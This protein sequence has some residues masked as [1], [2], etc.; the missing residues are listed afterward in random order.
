MAERKKRAT[1]ADLAHATDLSVKTVSIALRHGLGVSSETRQRVLEA[2]KKR[3]YG[4][5][6]PGARPSL[7]KLTIGACVP[8]L[9]EHY[10]ELA[11]EII[12]YAAMRNYAVVPQITNDNTADELRATQMFKRMGVF[13]VIL[14]SSRIGKA[15][16]K[17]LTDDGIAVVPIVSERDHDGI[18]PFPG[19]SPILLDHHAGTREAAKYLISLGHRRFAYLSGPRNSC[20]NVA[21]KGGLE[22]ALAEAGL[23]LDEKYVIA[24]DKGGFDCAAGYEECLDL[25]ARPKDDVPTA[26]VC[27]NDELALGVLA[28]L[29][30]RRV[31]VPDKMSVVGSDDIKYAQYWRPSLTTVGVPRAQLAQQAVDTIN[32]IATNPT[33]ADDQNLRVTPRL[34]IRG[35]SG[36]CPQHE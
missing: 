33:G 4:S 25:L 23:G 30:E 28:C 1:L 19:T 9:S 11:Q 21:K 34:I 35:S 6:S 22:E 8:D 15:A 2:A 3:G 20:S 36:P 26:V 17:D 32:D 13:A 14:T 5:E 29:A 12:R 10:G 7:R 16:V 18:G 24:R 31:S 27:Y